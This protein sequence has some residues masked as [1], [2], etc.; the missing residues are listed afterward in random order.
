MEFHETRMGHDFFTGQLP[1]LIKALNRVA[2]A[3]E[4]AN[5]T[6][7]E[8]KTEETDEYKKFK[9]IIAENITADSLMEFVSSNGYTVETL[10][11]NATDAV[12]QLASGVPCPRCGK[13][14]LYSDMPQYEYTC[15]GC[16]GY[17]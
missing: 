9:E 4:K 11:S 1:Q 7:P 17:F 15:S 14:L 3:M 6:K 16:H 5:E 8:V 2:N 10:L 13:I 12:S